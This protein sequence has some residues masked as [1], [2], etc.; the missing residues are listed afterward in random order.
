MSTA[1]CNERKFPGLPK[2]DVLTG[3]PASDSALTKIVSLWRLPRR[4]ASVPTSASSCVIALDA[5]EWMDGSSPS[6]RLLP[7]LVF[8]ETSNYV[9]FKNTQSSPG[10][11]KMRKAICCG[12]CTPV[13]DTVRSLLVL[14]YK[15]PRLL[16]NCPENKNRRNY[17]TIPPNELRARLDFGG[18]TGGA[19]GGV[20]EVT[21]SVPL[22]CRHRHIQISFPLLKKTLAPSRATRAN[23]GPISHLQS[24]FGLPDVDRSGACARL[25]S[26]KTNSPVCF[27]LFFENELAARVQTLLYSTQ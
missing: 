10:T 1:G 11:G 9:V 8:S 26:L 18:N 5:R 16:K 17:R 4:L 14:R 22:L 25:S 23:I 15:R 2:L 21:A 7:T 3:I 27:A 19:P 6:T 24:S 13:R 20:D 12:K